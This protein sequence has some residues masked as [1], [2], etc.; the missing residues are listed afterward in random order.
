MVVVPD[1]AGRTAAA[2]GIASGRPQKRPDRRQSISSLGRAHLPGVGTR[3]ARSNYEVQ[4]D[5]IKLYPRLGTDLRESCRELRRARDSHERESSR[6]VA[7]RVRARP[8]SGTEAAARANDAMPDQGAYHVQQAAEKLTKAALV[9]HAIRPRKGHEI[10]RVREAAAG[11]V[12][13]IASAFS[14]STDSPTTCGPTAT[15]EGGSAS[16]LPSPRRRSARPGSRKSKALKADFER[17]LEPAASG[18][19]R[20]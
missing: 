17:W 6:R 13:R 15:R 1:D 18:R 5:G 8:Q 16:R 10:R 12:R 9:A 2:P 7:R 3:S 11:N 4:V 19:R 14:R 20:S